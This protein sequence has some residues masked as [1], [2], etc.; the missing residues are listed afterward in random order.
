MSSVK[1]ILALARRTRAELVARNKALPADPVA[2]ASAKGIKITPQQARIL[3]ALTQPPHSVLVRAAHAVGKTFIASLA[4]SWFYDLHNPGL[5]LTTAPTHIQVAD[6]LFKELRNVRR[7]DPHFLPKATRLE[8]NP[9]HFIHGLTANK[10]DAF[11]GRHGTALMIVFDE[12][13]GVDK[14]FWERART[15]LSDGP[16]YCFL[17]IYNP[18]D[19]SSPAYAEEASGRHTV[20]EMSAL[21]HPNVTSKQ[22]II[23]GAVTYAQVVERLESECKRLAPDEP[24]PWNAFTFEGVTY[25]PEDPLFEIQILGRWPTRAINSV[26]GDSALALLLQPMAVEPNWLVAIGCDVARFGDDRT[27]MVVRRGRCIIGIE[28]HR[29]WTITQTAQRLKELAAE[30]ATP[31]QHAT[32]IPIYIDEGGLGAG[33]VDCC[34]A[35]PDRHNFVGVNSSTVSNWPGDFPNLRSE[36]W[37]LAAELARDG[38]L[39]MQSLP[40]AAQQ[41][42]LAELKAPV[43]VVDSMNRRVVEAKTQTKR[44]LGKSPDLADAFNLAC[45]LP[46]N[47]TVERVTGHL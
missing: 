21:D 4:A 17:G 46:A 40:L 15:M 2:Y 11:Q 1:R 30:H 47:N 18:Y 28:A 10:A 33:V 29:G 41:Q 43:F 12:A 44:R 5:V 20:L 7:N 34:G 26:W 36:L 23:P 3:Q 38:N 45:Y 25:L 24:H 31:N 14:I 32:R 39:S 37:F 6:L 27:V 19:V 13:A 16:S 35:G 9:N 42:L 8:E 22:N